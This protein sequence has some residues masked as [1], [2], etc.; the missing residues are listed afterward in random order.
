MNSDQTA[1][2]TADNTENLDR[3][4]R[5]E[6]TKVSSV[7]D[8]T[9]VGD[10]I[11]YTITITN[12]GNV[13]VSNVTLSDTLTDAQGADLTMT[14]GPTFSASDSDTGAATDPLAPGESSVYVASYTI[15][16]EA[17][18]AGGVSNVAR[19]T[20]EAPNGDPVSDDSDDGDDLDGNTEDDPTE[21]PINPAPA[22]EVTKVSSVPDGTDVGDAIDYTITITNVGN[23]T[24]SNVTLSDTL[25]DAQGA[26]LTMTS[27]PTFSASDSDTGA[28]TDP[29][30]PGESSVYVASYTITQEAIDAG[31]VSN[32]ARATGEAPNGDPVSDDSDDGDDLDGNTEDD[33][34]DNPINRNPLLTLSK[35]HALTDDNDLNG[36][37]TFGDGLTYTVVATNSGNVTLNDLVIS[38]PLITPSEKLCGSLGPGETCSLIGSYIVTADDVRHGRIDNTASALTQEIAEPISADDTVDVEPAL[39]DLALSKTAALISDNDGGGTLTPED[40]IEFTLTLTNERRDDVA[41]GA[42]IDIVVSER[43]PSRY[44]YLSHTGDGVYDSGTG[45]WELMT[46]SLGESAVLKIRALVGSEGHFTNVT[47]VV[48]TSSSDPDSQP[49]NDNGDQS[50]DDEAAAPQSPVAGISVDIGTPVRDSNGHYA[51]SFTVLIENTGIVDLCDISLVEDLEAVFG[52][53]SIVSVTSP[54]ATGD[55]VPNAS[56]DGVSDTNLLTSGCSG[57]NGSFSRISQLS[58][59]FV[60]FNVVIN[61]VFDGVIEYENNAYL[62]ATSYDLVNPTVRVPV[63]DISTEGPSPDPNG[64]G[65]PDEQA[66]N[67]IRLVDEAKIDISIRAGIPEPGSDGFDYSVDLNLVVENT[68]NVT[69]TNIDVGLD[70]ETVF[71]DGYMVNTSDISIS[72][73]SLLIS[74]GFNGGDQPS[75]IASSAESGVES[76]MSVGTKFNV[77]VPVKFN[78]ESD[79]IFY[80]DTQAEADSAVGPTSDEADD[81]A[82]IELGSNPVLG[83]SLQASPP[84]ET[85]PSADPSGRC[86]NDACVTELTIRVDNLGNT[87]LEDLT[88]VPELGG[89]EGLPEGTVIVIKAIASSDGLGTPNESLIEQTFVIGQDDIPSLLLGDGE[90][91]LGGSGSVTVTIEFLLPPGTES[92]SFDISADG[93]AV[94][95]ESGTVV[96]DSSDNG[97]DTDREGDGPGNNS[98]PTPLVV[99]GQPIIGVVAQA[100]D[101]SDGPTMRLVDNGDASVPLGE[102]TLTYQTSF[103]VSISNLGNTELTDVDA[104]NSLETSFPTIVSQGADRVSVVSE[105]MAAYLVTVDEF[106]NAVETPLTGVLNP[107]YDGITDT[108]LLIPGAITL[109]PGQSIVIRYDVRVAV[110]YS[111]AETLEELQRQTFDT[112]VLANGTDPASGRTISD[113]SNDGSAQAGDDLTPGQLRDLM[114][115]DGD[116]DPNESGENQP[117]PLSFPGGLEGYM[118]RDT[119]GDQVCT[120]ADEPLTGW[121]IEL[122]DLEGNPVLDEN[123]NAVNLVIDSNGYFSLASVP[124]GAYQVR[125]ITPQGVVAGSARGISRAL[126]ILDFIYIIDPGGVVYDSVSGDPVGGVKLYLTDTNGVVLPSECLSPAEQ[127]GQVTGSL[128]SPSLLGLTAGEY[129]FFVVPG[130][131]PQCP[132]TQTEYRISVDES[133]LPD[134]YSLSVLKLPETGAVDQSAVPCSVDG[135]AIDANIDTLRCEITEDATPTV[136]GGFS[137]FFTRFLIAADSQDLINN[138][139]PLDPE[140]D[141][142]V[143]ITKEALKSRASVGDLVPYRLRVENMT[144]LSLAG[145]TLMDTQAAGFQL[146]SESLRLRRAGADGILETGDD[147]FS[148]LA[149][150]GARPIDIGPFSLAESEV[151]FVEYVMRVGSGVSLG[152]Q[153]NLAQPYIGGEIVGNSAI[154]DVEVTAD[155]IFDLTTLLGKVFE[156]RNGN[157]YQDE[158]EPGIAG[159]RIGTV[160][161]EWI[162]TDQYGRYSLPGVDPGQNA[163]GR[164][165]ILKLDIASLPEGAQLTTENPRVLRIT[166]GLMNQID[167]GVRFEDPET[168]TFQRSVTEK[169]WETRVVEFDPVYLDSGQVDIKDRYLQGMK[170]VISQ[171]S[172]A[173]NINFVISGHTDSQPLSAR[174]KKRFIDNDTLS[175]AR[176]NQVA[177][178]LD[179]MLQIP[180][181]DF[182]IHGYGETRPSA[183]NDDPS[184]MAENRR[185]DISMVY[186]TQVAK[187]ASLESARVA[188]VVLGAH[189]LEKNSLSAAGIAVLNEIAEVITENNFD[190]VRVEIPKDE[191]YVARKALIYAYIS[192]LLGESNNQFMHRL[193]VGF[194]QPNREESQN[195][196]HVDSREFQRPPLWSKVLGTVL[197]VLV[198]PAWAEDVTCLSERLCSDG[199]LH[200]FVTETTP[201]IASQGPQ[202]FRIDES[203]LWLGQAPG[204]KSPRLAMRAQDLIHVNEGVAVDPLEVWIDTNIADQ[205]TQWDIRV[206][207]DDDVT[208]RQPIASQSGAGVVVGEPLLVDLNTRG[209][210]LKSSRGVVWEIQFTD[211]SG[212]V[213]RTR[214]QTT[215]FQVGHADLDELA[216]DN[217]QTWLEQLAGQNHLIATDM[218]LPGD[219]VSING[220]D[221]PRGGE[222]AVGVHRYPIGDEGRLLVEMHL[223]P[224]DYRLPVALYDRFGKWL[225]EHS[226]SVRVDGE[227]FFMMGLAD[228]TA[229]SQSIKGNMELLERDHHQDGDLWVDGRLAFFLKGHI[230]GKYL[231]T[232]QMDTEEQE[233]KHLFDDMDRGDTTKLFNRIDPDR[234]Y[235]VYGDDSRVIR[236]VDTSGKFYVRVDWDRSNA[237]WG[238]F[239]SSFTGTELSLHNRSLYGLN[240]DYRSTDQTA[241]GDDRTTVK[242]FASEP[243]TLSARDE[244]LGTGGSLYYLSHS[245][246]A[247]GSEK[248]AVEVRDTV[249]QRVREHIT[250]LEGRDYEIDPFQGRII[251]TR[252]LRS[253]AGLSVLSII[254]NSPLDGDDVYLVVDYEYVPSGSFNANNLTGGVR[255]KH[256]LND[257]LAIGATHI[258]EETSGSDFRQLGLD[259][260][261]K[262]TDQTWVTVETS[263]TEAFQSLTTRRSLDG[264]ISYRGLANP[265]SGIGGDAVAV[266]ANVDLSDV[267]LKTPGRIGLWYRDQDPGFSAT[268]FSNQLGASLSTRGIEGILQPTE[269]ITFALR[270]ELNERNGDENKH[271]GVQLDWQTSSHTTV[272][273]QYQDYS[274]EFMGG[275]DQNEA[276]GLRVTRTMTE[277]LSVFANAQ[278]VISESSGSSLEDMVGAGFSYRLSSKLDASGEYFSDGD[279][280]GSRFGIGW[281]HRENSTSYLNYVTEDGPLARSGV[282]LG[283]RTNI[284]DRLRVYSEHRFDRSARANVE[285]D[286]YGIAYDFSEKW[287]LEADLL[288]SDDE[289]DVATTNREAISFGSRYRTDG[290][291]MVNRLELRQE[292]SE[293]AVDRE[294]W[295]LTNRLN[296]KLSTDWRMLVKADFAETDNRYSTSL[297]S[298]YGE[299]DLGFA[300]RPVDNNR[301]NG[302]AM[303][304]YLYDLDPSTQTG[305]LYMDEKG[306]VVSLEG[307]YQLSHRFKLGAKYAEKQ[308]EIRMDRSAGDFV[309]A[310]TRLGIIRGRVHLVNRIDGLIE[311]RQLE[312][313]EFNDKKQGWLLGLDLQLSDNMSIGVG[314]N[315]TDFNDRLTQ[316]SYESKGWFLNASAYF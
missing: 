285:G 201:N 140:I 99:A 240:L 142:L 262:A 6:V 298:R 4:P 274:D 51:L 9:D 306:L 276:L 73:S 192:N 303:I 214:T 156:D 171:L 286:S 296:M 92:E 82:E 97:S 91:P 178:A 85:T 170:A 110:D 54:T 242:A 79:S 138:H 266:N 222:L 141:G 48:S 105:S 177:K 228:L 181:T 147:E 272:S 45:L 299:F 14:S 7:P 203:Q 153:R 289:S 63:T 112:Q 139:I 257:H 67:I 198:Q 23:V 241:L 247:L 310:N 49:N 236:D 35:S 13:T 259:L 200:I 205:I 309:E 80:V 95:P 122:T 69:L 278:S 129:Q 281:R 167:F 121:T 104:L 36:A 291:T 41:T 137:D 157:G 175:V 260:T 287:T 103:V 75:L 264:G 66:P 215:E 60:T 86:E 234:H 53:G 164:K 87:E 118:C 38:D 117:T 243:H 199:N 33:P 27:G 213:Y 21:N 1:E 40:E 56:Y 185:V 179:S 239:N 194:S 304:S 206:F 288:Q 191:A 290:M 223:P 152:M 311:Y 89:L 20:G 207:A 235:P 183:S 292:E 280:N 197:S 42:A 58:D 111:D 98:Q 2:A 124:E 145:I 131:A 119:D 43:L 252:P 70:L 165:A 302:L 64:D 81:E 143:L 216:A 254:R 37:V 256:W 39:A 10:A 154:A 282:T 277:D 173:R 17:I 210:P 163:W 196:G 15:T 168:L 28:A 114:D 68:G 52:E 133:S 146:A 270:S 26:D 248:V 267:G 220:R 255:A 279:R 193:I 47:E 221:L 106:G 46:L 109:L 237:V 116:F 284:T 245:D 182:V 212:N 233:L 224:G 136:A 135:V 101:G 268:Q 102:R 18:D 172:G 180:D 258:T 174:A 78:A 155:P 244:I 123:G 176:A 5:L 226:V 59:A 11:D 126:S 77:T 134:G 187:T 88:L 232:A 225:G 314:Y 238:N 96:T 50:E 293:G 273:A 219:L 265:V 65:A 32:V 150:A 25:T 3:L 31:G 263:E 44:Q 305:G 184:G 71:V 202:A 301:F 166:G 315:F 108:N 294:Q 62:T 107:N 190:S 250:L 249:N 271:L 148:E 269:R 230:Q 19:A 127:Q 229:G 312:V 313:K 8:G 307:M 90:L 83:V 189:H 186:E 151:I 76:V 251:L 115:S 57:A 295:V 208:R 132:A 188:T 30:A 261:L 231:I 283:Q 160:K 227:Y 275:V 316:L 130:A 297:E 149:V 22:L 161:G 61:P 74:S 12:V 84:Q 144:N 169:T 204:M 217:D 16:Q 100:G 29:L 195:I 158:G 24:V 162:L 94:D 55:L 211:I 72:T 253:T 209:A 34:T 125:F 300:Y 113:L 308:S 93:A 246:V 128:T 159:A 120:D 218:A